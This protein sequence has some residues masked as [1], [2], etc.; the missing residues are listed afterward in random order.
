MNN[1]I[2]FKKILITGGV[3]DFLAI[4]SFLSCNQKRN[5]EKIILATR[6]SNEIKSLFDVK[7]TYYSK[8]KKIQILKYNFLDNPAFNCKEMA[9][10][11][12]PMNGS[13]WNNIY[14]GSI[15]NMFKLIRSKDLKFHKS[16]FLNLNINIKKFKL[17]ERFLLILPFSKNKVNENRDFNDDDWE[18]LESYLI[19]NKKKGVCI[20]M[21]NK[22]IPQIKNLINL[23]NQ[24][25]ML[26][27]IEILKKS[28]GYIGIDSWIS[29]LAPKSL[30]RKNIYIKTISNHCFR[31]SS[32]YF[33][34][35]VTKN[36]IFSNLKEINNFQQ[37]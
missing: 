18:N 3:G 31:F 33:K 30:N 8:L 21:E 13:F 16:S 26:E 9:K 19:N 4:D 6:A 23:I 34:P 1:D 10:E 28:T 11:F 35:F 32:I 12:I 7:N 27:S 36:F 29:V 20:G 37:K 2:C 25:T 24:T 14:D 5:I 17:P 15:S 22:K